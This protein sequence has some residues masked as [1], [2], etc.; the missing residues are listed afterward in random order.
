LN[1]GMAVYVSGE[2]PTQYVRTVEQLQIANRLQPPQVL[3]DLL[4]DGES[5]GIAYAEGYSFVAYLAKQEGDPVLPQLLAALR[6]NSGNLDRALT[7][8]TGKGLTAWWK[9]WQSSL[10]N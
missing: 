8:V 4:L 2:N 9:N 7:T 1:E 3:N 10:N 5:A 6:D